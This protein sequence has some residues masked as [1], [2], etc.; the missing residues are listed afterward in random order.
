M[1][2]RLCLSVT[3]LHA[4]PPLWPHGHPWVL[5]VRAVHAGRRGV[6]VHERVGVV[7]LRVSTACAWLVHV[8]CVCVCVQ[9]VWACNGWG[10]EVCTLCN[11]RVLWVCIA[12]ERAPCVCVCVCCG[13]A[14]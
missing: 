2:T 12:R 5:K 3:C 9:R 1:C 4:H 7:H 8:V 6:S 10:G 13:C 14:L 11:P